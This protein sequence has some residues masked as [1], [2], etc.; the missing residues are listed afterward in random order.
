MGKG[1]GL[2]EGTNDYLVNVV[3]R[4]GAYGEAIG[5]MQREVVKVGSSK[6]R[7]SQRKH[8]LVETGSIPPMR[9]QNTRKKAFDSETIDRK[10]AP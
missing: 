10:T 1:R 8:R 7:E 5:A 2:A 6:K 9:R 3:S 4:F